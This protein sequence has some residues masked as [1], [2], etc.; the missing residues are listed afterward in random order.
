MT[1]YSVIVTAYPERPCTVFLIKDNDPLKN[2][3]ESHQTLSTENCNLNNLEKTINKFSNHNL[4]CVTIYGPQS[5]ICGNIFK[6]LEHKMSPLKF[7]YVGYDK[8]A[9]KKLDEE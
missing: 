3:T 1:G 9:Q 8:D 5:Y 6:N 4:D 7:V 2:Y